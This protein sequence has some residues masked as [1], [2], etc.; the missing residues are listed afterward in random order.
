MRIEVRFRGLESTDSLREYAVRQVHY[1]LSRFG[2]ELRA[3]VVRVCDINGPKG[4]IDKRCHVLVH[5]RRVAQLAVEE[6]S[7]DAQ[8]AVDFAL[9]RM[10][11]AVGHELVR[12]RAAGQ[13]GRA[14]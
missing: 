7:A 12:A 5:G 4:G 2:R 3:V 9:L 8:S 6:M 1:H 10:A 11:R 14:S 13:L